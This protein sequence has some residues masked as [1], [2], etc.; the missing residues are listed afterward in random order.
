MNR[1]LRIRIGSFRSQSYMIINLKG[2]NYH[3]CELPT[4]YQ[5]LQRNVLKSLRH[6]P[7]SVLRIALFRAASTDYAL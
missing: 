3:C 7:G 1:G 6:S 2:E 5:Y 4:T